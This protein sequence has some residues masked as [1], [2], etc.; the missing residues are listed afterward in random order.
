MENITF[1]KDEWDT[2]LWCVAE[3]QMAIQQERVEAL[4][5]LQKDLNSATTEGVITISIKDNDG[6]KKVTDYLER[7][8]QLKIQYEH[9][10]AIVNKIRAICDKN[11][12]GERK[13]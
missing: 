12:E 6:V 8:E 1:T 9:Y 5:N 10:E 11:H 2:I 3:Q 13:Q 4:P 7:S